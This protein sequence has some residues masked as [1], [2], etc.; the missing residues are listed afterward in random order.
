MGVKVTIRKHIVFDQR[1]QEDVEFDQFQ[2]LIGQRVVGYKASARGI[3][4]TI[5]ARNL[6]QEIL[7]AIAKASAD[8]DQ[9]SDD[10]RSKLGTPQVSQA[11]G[12]QARP[13]PEP[14]IDPADSAKLEASI[15]AAAAEADEPTQH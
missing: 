15:E 13:E 14:V 3:P 11:I 5:I 12:D 2:I 9:L 7:G 4:P 6:S 1:K 10:E 8:H